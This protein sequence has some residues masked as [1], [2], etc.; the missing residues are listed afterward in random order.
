MEKVK[1]SMP[2]PMSNI[3]Q[4][5]DTDKIWVHWGGSKEVRLSAVLEFILKQIQDADTSKQDLR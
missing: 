1:V 4:E 2:T 3:R 5:I